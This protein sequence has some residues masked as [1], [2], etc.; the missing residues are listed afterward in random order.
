[1]KALLI[2][3]TMAAILASSFTHAKTDKEL[4]RKQLI[5]ATKIFALKEG[6]NVSQVNN[7]TRKIRSMSSMKLQKTITEMQGKGVPLGEN[8]TNVANKLADMFKSY[9]DKNSKRYKGGSHMS[10]TFGSGKTGNGTTN[11]LQNSMRPSVKGSRASQQSD[12]TDGGFF[13]WVGSLLGYYDPDKAY[14]KDYGTPTTPGLSN[15][16]GPKGC[17]TTGCAETPNP[18]H[19]DSSNGRNDPLSRKKN[20]DKINANNGKFGFKRGKK[21]SSTSIDPKTGKTVMNQRVITKMDKYGNP[22]HS[23][24]KSGLTEQEKRDLDLKVTGGKIK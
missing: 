11:S 8:S 16:N 17:L 10:N 14:E 19:D 23:E 9:T 18:A 2:T 13:R 12:S 5:Q 22:I 4:A 24:R 21:T 1:M 7:T 15:K 20:I 3:I 6:I